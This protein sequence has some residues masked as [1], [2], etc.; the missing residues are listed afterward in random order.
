ME[1]DIEPLNDIFTVNKT[2]F[3]MNSILQLNKVNIY[4]GESLVLSDVN[5]EIQEGDKVDEGQVLGN[6][7]NI[8]TSQSVK[9]KRDLRDIALRDRDLFIEKGQHQMLAFFYLC[10]SQRKTSI[11]L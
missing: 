5:F 7:Y 8:S 9:S 1:F 4:Q 11:L 10:A 2:T 6:V 3:L